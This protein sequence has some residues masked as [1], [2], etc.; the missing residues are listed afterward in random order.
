MERT[1][2][3]WMPVVIMLLAAEKIVQHIAVT[4]ALATDWHAI[5]S[6]VAVPPDVLVVLGGIVAVMFAVALWGLI[7]RHERAVSLL[8]ALALFDML[9]EFAAQGTLGIQLNVSFL[10]ASALL[11]LC[12]A[13]RRQVVQPR[14]PASPIGYK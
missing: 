7:R 14:Q 3:G 4:A 10:V 11:L 12:L 1:H 9:G 13:Y 8:I 2:R 6:T 5:R